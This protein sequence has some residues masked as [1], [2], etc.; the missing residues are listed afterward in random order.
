VSDKERRKI[1]QKI[2]D[3]QASGDM[4]KGITW[5]LRRVVLRRIAGC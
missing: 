4:R 5:T 1:A 2:R 3:I